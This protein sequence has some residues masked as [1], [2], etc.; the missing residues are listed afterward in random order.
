LLSPTCPQIWRSRRCLAPLCFAST[1]E[2]E[3]PSFSTVYAPASPAPATGD[4][5][6]SLVPTQA[7]S[8]FVIIGEHDRALSLHSNGLTPHLLPPSPALQGHTVDVIHHWSYLA[9]I[10][11]CRP[12]H[13][14]P[15]SHRAAPRVSSAPTSLPGAPPPPSAL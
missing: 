1:P 6:S 8:P 5:S 3:L 14:P 4:P 11:R 13:P 12:K 2:L 7:P 10:K 9:A 15:P